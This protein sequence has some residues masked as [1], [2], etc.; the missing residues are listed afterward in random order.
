[1][2]FPRRAIPYALGAMFLGSQTSVVAQVTT[3][4]PS[5]KAAAKDS[6]PGIQALTIL[7]R[8]PAFDGK[9]FGDVGAYEVIKARAEGWLDP[10]DP[11][12]AKVILLDKAPADDKGLVPYA[13]EIFIYRP[14]DPAKATGDVFYELINRGINRGFAIYNQGTPTDPGNGFL[15]RQGLTYVYSAWQPEVTAESPQL[16]GY[17]PRV[18]NADGSYVTGGVIE[19][20][21]PDSAKPTESQRIDGDSLIGQITYP[22]AG[23][24]PAEAGVKLSVRENY[25]DPRRPLPLDAIRFL[26]DRNIRI[27]M[28]P[29]KAMGM[30]AGAIYE[31]IYQ[32][33]DP[34]P[35]AIGFAAGR[36]VLSFL[37]NQDKDLLGTLNPLREQGRKVRSVVSWGNSQG[38]RVVRDMLHLGFNVDTQGRK[39]L[40]GVIVTVAG[41]RKS[42]HGMPFART[43]VWIRQHE[44]HENPGQE[45][46]FAYN[47]T[48][49]A[50]TGE[51]GGVLD[52]CTATNSCPKV[53]HEDTDAETWHGRTALITTGTDGKPLTLPDN[54]R[55]YWMSGG[56]HGSGN[57]TPRVSPI[58]KYP[59][60]PIDFQPV[61][62]GLLV[63]MFDWINTGKEPPRS[64]FPTLKDG[65]LSTVAQM[66]TAYPKIPGQP[67]NP[68]IVDGRQLDFSALPAK[69]GGNYPLFVPKIDKFGNGTGGVPLPDVVVPLG[70]YSGR[71]FRVAGH[72]ENEICGGSGSIIPLPVTEAKRKADG[73]SR[74]SLEALYPGGAEDFYAKR[75]KAVDALIAARLVLPEERESYAREASFEWSQKQ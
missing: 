66:G 55:A 31:L 1:M 73:D 67:F 29:A 20:F 49:D 32:G 6:A 21:I 53:F 44:E 24:T 59:V 65:T 5:Y 22:P 16:K 52:A 42:D 9:S 70:T 56:A 26:D 35:G 27:D 10:K 23:R 64:Y 50:L 40:D 28:R 34:Y 72:A 43:S 3:A 61:Y 25:D 7:S 68:R 39:L 18:R 36:D 14:V 57:G 30:D 41:S 71:N 60:N 62:R 69:R 15:M 45:F 48:T 58:C 13:V 11:A 74:P 46:P 38:G 33:R 75:L 47:H 37:R 17:F 54:V 12:N 2:R 4:F 8:G 19:N 63:S 51:E